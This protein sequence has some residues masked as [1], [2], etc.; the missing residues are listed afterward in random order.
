MF[1]VS[2][3]CR[4][5]VEWQMLGP[6]WRKWTIGGVLLGTVVLLFSLSAVEQILHHT[7]PA[8]LT[9]IMNKMNLPPPLGC[10]MFYHR[11]N[12]ARLPV[13]Y[14][15]LPDRCIFIF[16]SIF[17]NRQL[18]FQLTIYCVSLIQRCRS[19]QESYT[20]GNAR[21]KEVLTQ[22]FSAEECHG[23]TPVCF[24]LLGRLHVSSPEGHLKL[25][26]LRWGTLKVTST[27]EGETLGQCSQPMVNGVL[28]G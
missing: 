14:F 2:V 9:E 3:D 16:T 1:N 12:S 20:S 4:E 8:L 27:V 11:R 18:S 21:G 10:Q 26:S 25:Q 28:H 15:S 23:F 17:I 19:N 13:L 6:T 24:T 5:L 22:W 7:L